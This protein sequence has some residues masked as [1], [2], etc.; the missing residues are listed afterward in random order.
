MKDKGPKTIDNVAMFFAYAYMLECESAERY[1][2]MADCMEVHN[3]LEVSEL[4]Q[5]MA[6]HA[7]QRVEEVSRRT[8][9]IDLPE[10]PPWEFGW[11]CPQSPETPCSDKFHYLMSTQQALEVALYNA[12][13]GSEFYAQVAC[14]SPDKNVRHIAAEYVTGALKHSDMLKRWMAKAA[15]NDEEPLEDLDPPNITE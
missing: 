1:Q 13:R 11:T 15:E 5:K 14:E 9:G 4:F 12:N 10:I 8:E 6:Q 3:N 2:D 7:E